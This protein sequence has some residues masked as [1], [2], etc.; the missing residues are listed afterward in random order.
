VVRCGLSFPGARALAVKTGPT[1]ALGPRKRGMTS[2]HLLTLPPVLSTGSAWATCA[3][4]RRS[5]T[6]PSPCPNPKTLY[7]RRALCLPRGW[8]GESR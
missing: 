8:L 1:F 2:S 6:G 5:K 3:R 4:I 7:Q